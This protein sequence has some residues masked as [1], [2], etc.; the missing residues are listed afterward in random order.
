MF[1]SPLPDKV[2]WLYAYPVLYFVLFWS[3]RPLHPNFPGF[4]GPQWT[5]DTDPLLPLKKE[6][7]EINAPFSPGCLLIVAARNRLRFSAR[8]ALQ[9]GGTVANGGRCS[10]IPTTGLH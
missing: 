1:A 6:A 9:G 2:D 7:R 10:S 5:S 4:F 3:A 8:S